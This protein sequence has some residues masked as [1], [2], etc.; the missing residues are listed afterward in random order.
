MA[1]ADKTRP[2]DRALM[3][4]RLR[5]AHA[6]VRQA[7]I[8]LELIDGPRRNATV[9]SSAVLAG[10]AAAD[11]VCA[12]KLGC[13]AAGAHDQA[14]RTMRKVHGSAKAVADLSRLL[15][16]KT[17]SQYAGDSI[18]DRQAGDAIVR[19]RRLAAYAETHRRG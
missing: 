12:A 10:I 3:E 9:V 16:I 5:D 19:A 7:E 2:A 13:V 14:G 15:A 18:T 11:A 8:S 6:F 17:A 4:T 1:R